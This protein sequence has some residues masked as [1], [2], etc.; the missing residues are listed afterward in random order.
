MSTLGLPEAE[1]HRRVKQTDANRAAYVRQVYGHNWTDP[2]HYD[3]AFD[4]GRL[5]YEIVTDAIVLVIEERGRR[6]A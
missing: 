3:L 4:T 5:D 2:G 1:A 6:N